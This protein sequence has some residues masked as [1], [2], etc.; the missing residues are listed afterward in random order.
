[1]ASGL[2]CFKVMSNKGLV[3]EMA[4]RAEVEFVVEYS[5]GRG[6]RLKANRARWRWRGKRKRQSEAGEKMLRCPD[7]SAVEVQQLI[8]RGKDK[9]R[10]IE[11]V[12]GQTS[13]EALDLAS[14]A[15][16][17]GVR[18]PSSR[19]FLQFLDLPIDLRPDL[20]ACIK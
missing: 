2:D 16:P 15:A 11:M 18:Y 20:P 9:C 6:K 10:L 12:D 4:G 3:I 19:A 1:M 13:K 5:E 14:F 17:N 8:Q 7:A